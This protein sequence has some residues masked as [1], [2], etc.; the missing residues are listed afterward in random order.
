MKIP[1]D[2]FIAREKLT[3]YLLIPKPKNDKSG[4]LAQ[5]G[6]TQK[7]PDVLET[8]LRRL[9]AENEAISDREDEYGIFYQVSGQLYGTIGTLA[10]VTIWLQR[11]LDD[12]YRFVTLKPER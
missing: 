6:F 7:N 4:F 3:H 2:A 11:S 9:I 12:G 5:A 8:A 10:V 1:A